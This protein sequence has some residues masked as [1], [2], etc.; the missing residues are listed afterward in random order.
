MYETPTI[1]ELGSVADFTRALGGGPGSDSSFPHSD[2]V[3][4]RLGDDLFDEITTS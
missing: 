1:T 4:E 3:R 2:I